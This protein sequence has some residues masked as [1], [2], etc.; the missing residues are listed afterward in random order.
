[1]RNLCYVWN[2]MLVY[3]CAIYSMYNAHNM[4]IFCMHKCI[5]I[6]IIYYI[7]KL[8]SIHQCTLY[9]ILYAM[10]KS[11]QYMMHTAQYSVSSKLVTAIYSHLQ[12]GAALVVERCISGCCGGRLQ[13]ESRVPRGQG[14]RD[15][16]NIGGRLNNNAQHP[17]PARPQDYKHSLKDFRVLLRTITD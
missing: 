7:S 5:N 4:W 1:M 12:S 14:G 15:E 6:W 3:F 9:G 17:T 10:Q 16:C 2:S 11:T 13:R 8:S